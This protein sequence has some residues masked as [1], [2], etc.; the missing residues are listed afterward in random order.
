M[1]SLFIIILEQ[2]E[3]QFRSYA[4]QH[5]AK[6]THG[7]DIK[8]RH[9]EKLAN[10]I[11]DLLHS[12]EVREWR[13]LHAFLQQINRKM[14][15]MADQLSE[16]NDVIARVASDISTA[17]D[18]IKN[19]PAAPDLADPIAKLTAAATALEAVDVPAV[20]ASGGASGSA[21]GGATD[22]NAAGSGSGST[23]GSTTGS[24]GDPA[25]APAPAPA[26]DPATG[27]PVDPLVPAPSGT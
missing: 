22:P 14:D 21:S 13:E 23:T 9:N 19:H 25:P 26:L 8:G 4:A 12:S 11:R 2:C 7:A 18:V 10:E 3:L 1:S 20:V 6:G 15:I 5:Y 27:Q 16:L 24:T 17:V